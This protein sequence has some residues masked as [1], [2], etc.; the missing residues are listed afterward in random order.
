VRAGC[1]EAIV[2]DLRVLIRLGEEESEQLSAAIVDIAQRAPD[3][4][5]I[6]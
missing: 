1:Y 2:G 5:R 6:D 3:A 4:A